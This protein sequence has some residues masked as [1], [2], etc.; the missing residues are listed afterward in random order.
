MIQCFV[1]CL[2]IK[3]QKLHQIFTNNRPIDIL[4]VTISVYLI[5]ERDNDTMFRVMFGNH[6]P[7]QQ[8]HHNSQKR[9]QY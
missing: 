9:N 6:D 1:L 8:L 3:L 4:S 2:V 7:V 5:S